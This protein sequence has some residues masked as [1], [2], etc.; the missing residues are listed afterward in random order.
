MMATASYS[1]AAS[2]LLAVG[3]ALLASTACGSAGLLGDA[4]APAGPARPAGEA[5]VITVEVGPR[6]GRLDSAVRT[7]RPGEDLELKDARPDAAK[8][9]TPRA[10]DTAGTISA[11][12]NWPAQGPIPPSSGTAGAG[13]DSAAAGTNGRAAPA[14]PAPSAKPVGA[15]RPANARSQGPPV[16]PAGD[17]ASR[18]LTE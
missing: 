1:R 2:A 18:K 6:D 17:A 10:S 8:L 12:E 11:W 15:A 3:M 16:Q 4:P 14:T 5:Q 9:A 7:K 13:A